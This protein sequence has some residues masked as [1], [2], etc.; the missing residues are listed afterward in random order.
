MKFKKSK[1]S[2]APVKQKTVVTEGLMDTK[3]HI[4]AAKRYREL[5]SITEDV[6]LTE[7][8]LDKECLSRAACEYGIPRKELKDTL[9]RECK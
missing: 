4:D 9:C 7:E 2:P 6:Q 5:A 8:T 3:A 1:L